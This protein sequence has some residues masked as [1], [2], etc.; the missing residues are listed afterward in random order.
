ML[1]N[2]P[3]GA[4]ALSFCS[5]VFLAFFG[6]FLIT[7]G[8]TMHQPPDIAEL[9]DQLKRRIA[10]DGRR[11]VTETIPA[12]NP[13]RE[14]SRQHCHRPAEPKPR[15][16]SPRDTGA[17]VPEM[18][19]RIDN[20]CNLTDGARRCARKI[21]EY[22]YRKDRKNRSAEITVTYL[23][24]ALGRCRRTVQRYLRQLECEGY[25]Q[26]HVV[27]SERTRMCFGLLVRILDPLIPRH[28]RRRWPEKAIDRDVT[29]AS[30]NYIQ[31]FKRLPIPR[32]LW[33]NIC[34]DPIR[35]SHMKTLPAFSSL[36]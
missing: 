17:Y 26:V 25:I 12:S 3:P 8:E 4:S 16:P 34:C 15:F 6:G 19:S 32:E 30:Q 28:R 5:V 18:A 11:D 7:R 14:R 2:F 36:N 23:A 33:A 35:R 13:R 10:R 24:K 31:R 1:Q 20:D 21:S 29:S 27:P 22:I 9:R